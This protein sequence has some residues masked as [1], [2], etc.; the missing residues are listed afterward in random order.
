M[1]LCIWRQETGE[2]QRKV[3]VMRVLNRPIIEE[4]V[5]RRKP[6][7]IPEVLKGKELILSILARAA[8]EKEFMAQMAADPGEALDEYYTLTTEEK[9]ALISGDIKKVEGWVGKLD[10]HLATWLWA[11]LS[12]EKW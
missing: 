12:Q 6:I 2:K 11:R 1:L 10:S 8:N 5:E 4:K 7:I 9:A 3:S